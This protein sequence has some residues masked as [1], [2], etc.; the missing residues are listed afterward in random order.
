MLNLEKV[1]N[2]LDAAADHLDAIEGEKVSSARA[3][4]EERIDE[5]ASKYA[6]TTGEEMPDSIRAKLASSD[7]DVVELI[8]SMVEKQAGD[9]EALGGPS[10]R[11]DSN[12]PT[13]VKEAAD[14]AEDRFVS[15]INS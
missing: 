4:R 6:D 10:S 15:W 5:L 1:A 12:A 7:K 13:T 11:N 3:A 14:Q 2:V 9:L 8:T